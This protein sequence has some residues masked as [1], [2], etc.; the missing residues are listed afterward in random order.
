MRTLKTKWSSRWA[1]KHAVTDDV[2]RAAVDEMSRGL[3]DADLGG[4]VVK[5]RLPL[6]GRGKR[7]GARTIVAFR[8][9]RHTFFVY[10]FAKNE[11]DTIDADELDGFRVLADALQHY[12]DRQLQQAIEAGEL[13]EVLPHA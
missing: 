7:G 1:R 13:N 5:K 9:G 3:V 11:R 2:L 10:G 12:G 4:H 6:P 8:T